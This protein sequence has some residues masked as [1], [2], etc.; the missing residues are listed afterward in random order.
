MSESTEMLLKFQIISWQL[1]LAYSVK[2]FTYLDMVHFSRDMRIP[3][4]DLIVKL[5]IQEIKD[6]AR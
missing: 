6:Y 5:M 4:R 2:G 1:V 3:Q